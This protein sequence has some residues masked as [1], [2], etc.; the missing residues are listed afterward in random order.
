MEAVFVDG[1]YKHSSRK[2]LV[3]QRKGDS[4]LPIKLS[5]PNR[6]LAEGD[7]EGRLPKTLILVQKS[8]RDY[9]YV[10]RNLPVRR[11]YLVGSAQVGT[12]DVDATTTSYG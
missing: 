10:L 6:S 1:K 8:L 2:D 11:A 4:I 3:L 12:N 5:Q 7:I 9:D